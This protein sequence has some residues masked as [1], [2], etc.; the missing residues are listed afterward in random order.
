LLHVSH[1]LSLKERGYPIEGIITADKDFLKA[2][3]FLE[4]VGV[5]VSLT[6]TTRGR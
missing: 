1:L 2:E 3:K 5:K 4:G 6:S